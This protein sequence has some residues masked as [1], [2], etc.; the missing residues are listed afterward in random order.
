MNAAEFREALDELGVSQRR[1]A[2][3]W[4]TTP[5]SV[6]RWLFGVYPFPGWVEPAVAAMRAADWW[7][8][9]PDLTRSATRGGDHFG[10][11]VRLIWEQGGEVTGYLCPDAPCDR[12]VLAALQHLRDR[13]VAGENLILV[14]E[15][16]ADEDRYV[17]QFDRA[18]VDAEEFD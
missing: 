18:V 16:N 6:S 17:V 13:G 12:P 5:V 14:E 8:N 2:A 10:G 7:R 9:A 15:W 1:F 11:Y 3:I 4:G